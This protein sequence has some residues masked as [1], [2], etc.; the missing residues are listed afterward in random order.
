MMRVA[1]SGLTGCGATT[2]TKLVARRLRLKRIN[3]TFRDLAKDRGIPFAKMQFDK[4]EREFPKW[5]LLL[6]GKQVAGVAKTPRC[7]VGSR[8]AV[9][10]DGAVAKK[11]GK[12]VKINSK[13][14]LGVPLRVRA[15]RVARREGKPFAQA[16][17]ETRLR[18]KN[19]AARYKKLYGIDV[20]KRPR[21][22]IVIDAERLD[23]KGVTDAIVSE[24][25]CRHRN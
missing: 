14:W 10:L 18:D 15:G 1:V 3:Y 6:D 2:A 22:T 9:W 5:D 11:L 13:F 4:I 17:R 24:I 7:I 16:L 20:R 12:R 8:L 21:G 23:A 25:K 19:N